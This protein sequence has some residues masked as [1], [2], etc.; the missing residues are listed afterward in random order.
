MYNHHK[1]DLTLVSRGL[2]IFSIDVFTYNGFLPARL[3]IMQYRVF[4]SALHVYDGHQ[5][6]L[7][8]E[9]CLRDLPLPVDCYIG[10]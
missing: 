5:M 9:R 3:H 1:F 8:P 6:R 4:G 2:D 7:A 10:A